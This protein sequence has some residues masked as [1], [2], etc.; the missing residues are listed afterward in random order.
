MICVNAGI[1]L[2]YISYQYNKK[3]FYNTLDQLAHHHPQQWYADKTDIKVISTLKK[4][5]HILF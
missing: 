3:D 2:N 5:F 4:M 1:Q